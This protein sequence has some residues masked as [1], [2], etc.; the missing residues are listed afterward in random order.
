MDKAP[1]V[2]IPILWRLKVVRQH[3][4]IAPGID[5]VESSA[6]EHALH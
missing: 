2:L 4:H 3:E 6:K 1:V 5:R